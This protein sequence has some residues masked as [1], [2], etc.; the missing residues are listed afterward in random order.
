MNTT[1]K[2]VLRLAFILIAFSFVAIR[3]EAQDERQ[4]DRS[5]YVIATEFQSMR[6]THNT[7]FNGA[8]VSAGYH[9]SSRF[10]LSLAVEYSYDHFHN[11]NG[12]NLYN[13]KMMPVFSDLRWQMKKRNFIRP[14][15]QV[16]QGVSF[17]NYTKESQLGAFATHHV[18]EAGFY[19]YGGVGAMVDLTNNISWQLGLGFKAFHISTNVLEVNPHGTT[20]RTGIAFRF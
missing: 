19:V 2:G 20:L 7:F 6:S 9:L 17:I 10:I 1:T 8:S 4:F 11:D 3:A 12:W 14:Y 18:S 16:S 15:V 13:V 5:R